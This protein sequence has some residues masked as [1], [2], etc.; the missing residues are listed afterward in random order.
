MTDNLK[1]KSMKR[2][3][4]GFVAAI[5]CATGI[6][7][8][9]VNAADGSNTVVAVKQIARKTFKVSNFKEIS[10]PGIVDVNFIPRSSKNEV[11]VTAPSN[12]MSYVQVNIKG[13]VLSVTLK[14]GYN[15]ELHK[16]PVTATIY[17]NSL[18]GVTISGTGDFETSTLSA[19]KFT[20]KISGSG[21]VDIKSLSC[22]TLTAS[23]SGAGDIDID[24]LNCGNASFSV[25][26][27]GDIECDAIAAT[28]VSSTISGAGNIE[29]KGN[30]SSANYTV[31]GVGD[32]KALKLR[33]ANVKANA[34][35][36]GSI[37][38]YASE[39]ISATG[40]LTGGVRYAGNPAKVS[41]NQYVKPI[42]KK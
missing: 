7:M 41:I 10:L 6:C 31:S 21:D 24:A 1:I 28:S 36:A 42:S 9:S 37:K 27:A 12:I 40:S 20:L 14:P 13:G 32:I 18:S 5:L 2:I 38:C 29:L 11:V 34:S 26:G 16:K 4:L 17:G 22:K 15:Y 19:D 30:C 39:S 3:I 35:G 33:A 25:S 8:V 23:V